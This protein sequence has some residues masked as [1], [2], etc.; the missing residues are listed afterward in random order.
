MSY[1]RWN[2]TAWG[3]S[4]RCYQGSILA[5]SIAVA[6]FYTRGSPNTS[7]L[8]ISASNS[9]PR[10]WLKWVWRVWS[11]LGLCWCDDDRVMMDFEGYDEMGLF[12]RAWNVSKRWDLLDGGMI[13]MVWWAFGTEDFANWGL[14]YESI[15]FWRVWNVSN[16]RNPLI[17]GRALLGWT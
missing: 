10:L 2:F 8:P 1:R 17:V 3:N 6:K 5:A 16:W 15:G 11:K 7:A 12:W 14:F 4:L 13:P 9:R